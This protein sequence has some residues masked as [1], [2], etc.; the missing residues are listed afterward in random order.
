MGDRVQILAIT[1][2][3]VII[4]LIIGLIRQRRLR[5][6]YSII[7]LAAGLSLIVFSVWR[8]LL[9]RIAAFIGVYYA[10]AVLLLVGL[11]FGMLAFL[12]LTIVISKHANQNRTLAQEIALLK[13]EIERL[14][15]RVSVAP[16]DATMSKPKR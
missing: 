5:E 2:S 1:V 16:N 14:S 13:A 12:H 4:I 9:D 10:P 7:W 11:L 3:V 15:Q 6:E 8:G